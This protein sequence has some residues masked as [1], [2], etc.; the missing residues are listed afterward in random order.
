MQSGAYSAS[1]GE[2]DGQSSIADSKPSLQMA[3]FS[4]QRAG[5][6]GRQCCCL[7]PGPS[8]SRA[9]RSRDVAPHLIYP[10]SHPGSRRCQAVV[11]FLLGLQ[12]SFEAERCF[13]FD[14]NTSRGGI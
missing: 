14:Q 4:E 3:S 8:L 11:C 2:P 1:A 7:H 13:A 10:G 6:I 12:C 9:P 5:T